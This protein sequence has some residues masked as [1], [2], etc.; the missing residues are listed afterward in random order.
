[1]AAQQ[2]FFRDNIPLTHQII[3]DVGAQV[4]ELSAFF[5]A[6]SDGTSQILSVEPLSENIEQI[7]HTIRQRQAEAHWRTAT[8]AIS[9]VDGETVLGVRR[10]PSGAWNSSVGLVGTLPQ[11]RVRCCTLSLLCPEATVVKLDIEG[12]EYAVLTEA[13]PRMARVHTWAIEFHLV[14]GQAL[15]AALGQL[16]LAGFSLRAA[17]RRAD[18][19]SESWIAVEIPASLDWS[20]LPVAQRRA[21][22][23][24]FKMLHVLAQR[25]ITHPPAEQR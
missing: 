9:C 12:H 19:A 8:C 15:S 11:R 14:A 7:E 5:E 3:V 18:D 23:S 4:G 25:K 1:M 13:L 16:A 20:D 24:V 21:D 6:A 22:G 2:A 10:E 17:G